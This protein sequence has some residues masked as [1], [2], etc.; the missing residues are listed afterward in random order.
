MSD[1]SSAVE[2]LVIVVAAIFGAVVAR[3]RGA[4]DARKAGGASLLRWLG[5]RSFSIYLVHLP[6]LSSLRAAARNRP[7]S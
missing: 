1:P 6:I 7:D 2:V 5:E 4:G 3:G